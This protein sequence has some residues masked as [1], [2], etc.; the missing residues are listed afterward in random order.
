MH[1]AEQTVQI[2]C[3][4]FIRIARGFVCEQEDGTAHQRAGNRDPLL[5]AAGERARPMACANRTALRVLVSAL[6]R[7]CAQHRGCRQ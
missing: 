3:R 6:A 5:L 2:L 7:S 1:L 4:G